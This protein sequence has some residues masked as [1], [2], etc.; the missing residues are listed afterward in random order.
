MIVGSGFP[1]I[2]GNII[3]GFN[4]AV[5]FF[6]Q[7]SYDALAKGVLENNTFRNNIENIVLNLNPD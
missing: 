4:D 5:S 3:E 6:D 7:A 1:T 2:K